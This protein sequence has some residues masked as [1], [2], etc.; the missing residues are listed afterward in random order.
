M[1][2]PPV[3][4]I[5][6]DSGCVGSRVLEVENDVEPDSPLQLTA[7]DDEELAADCMST[8]VDH[9]VT[10][11]TSMAVEVPNLVV[12][13][14]VPVAPAA[15]CPAVAS[16]LASCVLALS[17]QTTPTITTAESRSTYVVSTPI[18]TVASVAAKSGGEASARFDTKSAS[19][20]RSM[21]RETTRSSTSATSTKRTREETRSQRVISM[22]EEEYRRYREFVSHL[23]IKKK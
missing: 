14:P 18:S 20:R 22:D 12:P 6:D 13:P 7:P 21:H 11:T 3:L 1:K 23:K 2:V 4:V 10:G 17:V 8:T 15:M 19:R 16:L 5:D 9:L